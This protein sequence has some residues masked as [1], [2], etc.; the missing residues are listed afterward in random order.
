MSAE[1]QAQINEL[2]HRATAKRKEL[3]AK[4]EQMKA[5]AAHEQSQG[6]S[7]V[8]RKL[9]ELDEA[10]REGWDNLSEAALEKVNQWLRDA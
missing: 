10:V 8:R 5:D 9:E 4:L 3:E 1:R 2:K 6:I 7:T